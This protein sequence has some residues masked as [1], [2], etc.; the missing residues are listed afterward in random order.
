MVI[1]KRMGFLAGGDSSM[2]DLGGQRRPG[3]GRLSNGS[4]TFPGTVPM[5]LSYLSFQ[6]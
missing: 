4:A 1:S 6:E 3:E 2:R 5:M